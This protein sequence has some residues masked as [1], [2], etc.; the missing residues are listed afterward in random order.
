MLLYVGT[1][2]NFIIII[3][4]SRK[5]C[6][7]LAFDIKSLRHTIPPTFSVCIICTLHVINYIQRFNCIFEMV[8]RTEKIFGTVF[9]ENLTSFKNTRSHFCF[10]S[11]R[12]LNIGKH[13]KNFHEKQNVPQTL[14]SRLVCIFERVDCS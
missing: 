5:M 10:R 9:V 7:S 4:S 11:N 2:I 14:S 8:Y 1:D 13:T 6:V 3:L 12:K